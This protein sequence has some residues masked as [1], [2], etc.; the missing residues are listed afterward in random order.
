MTIMP[1]TLITG[2]SSGLGKCLAMECASRGYPMVLVALPDTGLYRVKMELELRF[3]VVVY[4]IETDLTDEHGPQNVI[5]F[6]NH[7]NISVNVLINNAGVGLE[8]SFE[9]T[10]ISF[11]TTLLQLNTLAVVK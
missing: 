7:Q 5:D 1:H 9:S 4:M 3:N 10:P 2:A 11:C 6:C 8:S